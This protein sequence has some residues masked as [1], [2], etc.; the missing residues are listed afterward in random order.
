MRQQPLGQF[1]NY[2]VKQFWPFLVG[3]GAWSALIVK[4]H[5]GIDDKARKE[6]RMNLT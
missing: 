5:M 1:F 6:S 3:A 4:V 2:Q